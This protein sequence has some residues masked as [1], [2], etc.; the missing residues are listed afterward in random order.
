ME[1]GS[2]YIDPIG[3]IRALVGEK[4]FAVVKKDHIEKLIN[5]CISLIDLFITNFSDKRPTTELIQLKKQ[6][7]ENIDSQVEKYRQYRQNDQDK[8][9]NELLYQ[10]TMLDLNLSKEGI[11]LDEIVRNK[12]Y[13][14]IWEKLPQPFEP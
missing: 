13:S 8:E 10:M 11:S 12:I 6:I 4:K 14:S 9:A 7:E 1:W 2:L 5:L 3:N